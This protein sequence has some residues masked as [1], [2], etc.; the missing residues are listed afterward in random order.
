MPAW[1]TI[2]PAD[3]DAY[4]VGAQVAALRESALADGQAD[5]F[6]V[7]AP[8]V[9]ARI[10]N[11]VKSCQRNKLSATPN[12]VPPELKTQ[13]VCL[14]LV[15]MQTRLSIALRLTDEQKRQADRAEQ[16][17]DQVMRGDL[18]VSL[19]D[20]PLDVETVQQGGPIQLV[21]AGNRLSGSSLNGL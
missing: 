7:I 10:R 11:K 13:A 5:P 19:P 8:D 9:I 1:L 3:L 4:L 2:T 21:T 12:T 17:L 18:V 14:I 20:D 6:T 16:E 15:A